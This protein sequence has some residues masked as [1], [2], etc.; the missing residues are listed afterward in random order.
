MKNLMVANSQRRNKRYSAD[1]MTVLINAQIENSLNLH[2][3]SRDVLVL[4]NFKYRYMDVKVKTI[5]LNTHCFTGSKMWGVKW[6]KDN[7]YE[8]KKVTIWAHDLD[9][10]QNVEFK[11]PKFAHV[12]IAQYSNTKYNGGSIFWRLPEANDLIDLI[13]SELDKGQEREEPTLN[14][15]L[16]LKEYKKRVTVLNNTFNVG[17]SGFVKRYQRSEKPIH[18]CHFHPYNRLAWETHAL[19]RNKLGEISI[20]PRL[21]ALIRKYYPNLATEVVRK[22]IVCLPTNS[23]SSSSPA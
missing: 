19:D 6:V 23:L 1:S 16:R 4:G 14:R 15:I 7:W 13:C 2:W 20:T 5:N 17:C 22:E 8:G 18:V 3:K 11:E 21:E 10:W 9:A 12:G